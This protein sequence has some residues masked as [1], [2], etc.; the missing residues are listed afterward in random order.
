MTVSYSE[1][2]TFAGKEYGNSVPYTILSI[3]RVDQRVVTVT[4]GA[5]MNL[6][7]FAAPGVAEGPGKFAQANVKLIRI[8]NLD[9]TNYVRVRMIDTG[10]ETFDIKL[11]AKG[12]F[13]VHSNELRAN[14]VGGAFVAP[15]SRADF[16]AAQA[17][18][19][20]VD[21]EIFVALTS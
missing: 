10:G 9:D 8:K 1:S 20:N 17:D 6:I 13:V 14:I 7:E 11:P 15:F 16:I 2:V 21:I 3:Q 18:T 19:A 4:S 5:E 12:I